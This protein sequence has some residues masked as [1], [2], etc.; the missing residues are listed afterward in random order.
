[1]PKK[2][3][4]DALPNLDRIVSSW[5]ALRQHGVEALFMHVAA[6]LQRG[7]S[8]LPSVAWSSLNRG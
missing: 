8:L 2:F 7:A 4:V 5:T 6:G 1:M 3:S